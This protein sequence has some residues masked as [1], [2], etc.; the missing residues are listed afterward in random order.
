ME[1]PSPPLSKRTRTET[2]QSVIKTQPQDA[3][4]SIN[5]TCRWEF[6]L[7]LRL[8]TDEAVPTLTALLIVP[9]PCEVEVVVVG[10]NST[11]RYTEQLFFLGCNEAHISTH[12]PMCRP[13]WR[14][15]RRVPW[16]SSSVQSETS[17]CSWSI[18]RLPH[19]D[20]SKH[21]PSFPGA[22]WWCML[23]R[24]WQNN[25]RK[26]CDRCAQS[27]GG[28][29]CVKQTLFIKRPRASLLLYLVQSHHL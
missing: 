22:T 19:A 5:Y 3:P 29:K 14:V 9:L 26:K 8:L 24:W 13:N 4:I 28:T 11:Q 6:F 10:Q 21:R 25:H 12:K 23:H 27:L 17:C 18:L 7:T 2:F 16:D 15:T 1:G 20:R